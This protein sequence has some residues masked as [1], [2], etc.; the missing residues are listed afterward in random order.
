MNFQSYIILAV[1]IAV[2]L[3]IVIK[4]IKNKKEGKS[5]CSC[6]GN[7]GSCGM[8]CHKNND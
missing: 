4:G 2:F 1:V 7:C 3:A 6:G 8:D 5:S